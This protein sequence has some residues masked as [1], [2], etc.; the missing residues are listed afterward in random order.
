MTI[1]SPRS[2]LSMSAGR[3]TGR[4]SSVGVSGVLGAVDI[5]KPPESGQGGRAKPGPDWRRDLRVDVDD[6]V[7]PVDVD[8]ARLVA[9]ELALVVG[10]V[11]DDD[12]G[13]AAVHEASG[14]AVDTERAG[15]SLAGDGVGLEAGAVVDVHDVHLLVLA[16]VR[17]LEK[18]R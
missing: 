12:D 10:R 18:V 16:D 1:G 2:R 3:V 15:S 17:G 13:V 5:R 14:G 6:P 4:R 9:V 11:G 8:D 7:A